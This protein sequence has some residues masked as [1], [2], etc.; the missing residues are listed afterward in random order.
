MED[1]FK[2]IIEEL[3]KH[4]FVISTY[5]SYTTSSIYIKLDYGVANGIRIADHRGKKKYK[6]RYN[7][8]NDLERDYSEVDGGYERFYYRPKHIKK[9]VKKIVKDKELKLTRYGQANYLKYMEIEK[10]KKVNRRFKEVRQVSKGILIIGESGAGKTTSMRNLKP[11]E[12]FYI[13]CDKKG[14]SW[15]GWREQYNKEKKNYM[16]TSDASKITEVLEKISNEQPHIKNIIID[17]LNA[18]MIDD[19]FARMKE[20]TFDKWQDMASAIYF[21]AQKSNNLREDL[22]S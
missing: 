5:H 1:V 16:A 11:E 14:L 18:I 3:K 6:Y 19:E 2:Q 12:T 10:E 4:D 20:K 22:Y 21:I 17:T 9:L 13:D 15:R 7:V 8:M